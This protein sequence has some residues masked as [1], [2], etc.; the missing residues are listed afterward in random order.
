MQL[1]FNKL[2]R[3]ATSAVSQHNT[4]KTQQLPALL[5]LYFVTSATQSFLL[6]N[7]KKGNYN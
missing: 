3:H 2:Y 6:V 7:I 1:I 4:F 5:R